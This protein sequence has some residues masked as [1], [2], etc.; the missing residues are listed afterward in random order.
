MA[1]ELKFPPSGA[2]SFSDVYPKLNTNGSLR[3]MANAIGLSAPDV[4]PD[5]F[6]NVKY[7]G[8][9]SVGETRPSSAG[10]F[11][12][13]FTAYGSWTL[14]EV[15][16]WISLSSSSGSNSGSVT[17]TLLANGGSERNGTITLT[18]GSE[19]VE[20][21]VTQE[22]TSFP[23]ENLTGPHPT[24]LQTCASPIKNTYYI[25]GIAFPVATKLWVDSSGTTPANPGWYGNDIIAREWDGTAFLGSAI[26]C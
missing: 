20:F 25:S 9:N 2:M 11:N 16:S 18:R 1:Y 22:G 14:S 12:L 6:Y 17:V 7:L 15:E 21:V 4:F 13:P 3:N 26:P 5:D 8:F 10:G 24:S 19:S 23:A